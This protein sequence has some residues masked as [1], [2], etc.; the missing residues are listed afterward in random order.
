MTAMQT[1]GSY[2]AEGW[3]CREDGSLC[4]QEGVRRAQSEG[5]RLSMSNVTDGESGQPP[6]DLQG[7]P[8]ACCC[9]RG[10]QVGVTRIQQPHCGRAHN[11]AFA[12]ASFS[13]TQA[14]HTPAAPPA[15]NASLSPV[16]TCGSHILSWSVT[17]QKGTD[18]G[19]GEMP[20]TSRA[21]LG[22]RPHL[23]EGPFLSFPQ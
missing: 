15:G 3:T 4:W 22:E 21:T 7:T 19:P 13:G 11:L 17:P 6:L 8:S 5:S 9:G 16:N 12:N 2:R 23:S 14:P 1:N 20:L 18:S 10:P